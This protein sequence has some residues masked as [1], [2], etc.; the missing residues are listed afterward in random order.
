MG[1]S[2]N[3]NSIERSG[4]SSNNTWKDKHEKCRKTTTLTQSLEMLEIF[5]NHR[6]KE[7]VCLVCQNP[8]CEFPL[9][10]KMVLLNL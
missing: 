7:G 9:I 1:I 6:G 8:P 5:I 2:R 3:K 10:P 4:K